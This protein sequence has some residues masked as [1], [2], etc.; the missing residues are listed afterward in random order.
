MSLLGLDNLWTI[1]ASQ[2][3]QL[4]AICTGAFV[5]TAFI[6]VAQSQ[7]SHRLFVAAN[8]PSLQPEYMCS[9]RK[10]DDLGKRRV[11]C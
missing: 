9:G 7:S 6:H 1:F 8:F 3:K 2:G 4:D 11:I 5:G 10:F